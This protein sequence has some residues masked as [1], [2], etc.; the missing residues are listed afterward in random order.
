M[1]NVL[2]FEIVGAAD[3]AP[4]NMFALCVAKLSAE[5]RLA[6]ENAIPSKGSVV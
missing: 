2:G 3:K 1:R 4:I 5:T 6:A